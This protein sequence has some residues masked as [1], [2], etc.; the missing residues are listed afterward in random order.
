MNVV[1]VDVVPPASN[2]ICFVLSTESATAVDASINVLLVKISV[3][4]FPTKVSVTFGNVKVRDVVIA[5][6]S[7]NVVPVVEPDEENEI[8]FVASLVSANA[9]VLFD[10]NLLVSVSVVLRAT[11][12]SVASGIVNVRLVVEIAANVNV[13]PVVD[14]DE[15]NEIFL[16]KSVVSAKKHVLFDSNLFVNVSVVLR[17]MIVSVASGN[18]NVRPVVETDS[19]VNVVPAV[20]NDDEKPIFLVKSAL[21]T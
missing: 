3:V 21:S 19:K 1:E 6:E 12:V 4:V 11:M 15:E 17:A 10:S 2:L 8:F 7:V 5:H 13:V 9:H 14:D 18:V 20:D 16:V